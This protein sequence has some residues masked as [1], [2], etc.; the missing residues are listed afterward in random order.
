M[1]RRRIIWGILLAGAICLYLF[2]NSAATLCV[3][4]TAALPLLSAVPLLLPRRLELALDA[5]Q[6]AERGAAIPCALT[7]S[8]S[9]MPAQLELTVE[10]ENSFTGERSIRIMQLSAA[11]K[12]ARLFWQLDGTHSGSVRLSC[13]RIREMEAFGLFSRNR[14]CAAQAE[15]MIPQQTFPVF[16][17]LNQPAEVLLDS[18]AYSLQKAGADP[19]ETFRIRE[20]VPGD[21]IRQIHWKLSE[22]TGTLMV[23][24]LGLPAMKRLLLV[25]LPEKTLPPDQLDAMLDTLASVSSELLRQEIPHALLYAGE[26]HD[27]ADMADLTRIMALLLHSAP[28][29]E[30]TAAFLREHSTLPYAH[31]A[32]ITAKNVPTAEELAQA[33]YVS[34][35]LPDAENLSGTNERDRAGTYAFSSAALRSGTLRLEL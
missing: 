14:G 26:L 12:P 23:R 10:A 6:T 21:P 19:G 3:L 20:Y 35:L 1:A 29:Y 15:I 33:S 11:K 18:E 17:E 9:G 27:I 2:A 34:V 5:P 32:L 7:V 4:L 25:F 13:T 30:K 8:S 28:E 24:E 31:V 22:K 16:T